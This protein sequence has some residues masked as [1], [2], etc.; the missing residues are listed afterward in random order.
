M[1]RQWKLR[2]KSGKVVS[3]CPRQESN[4]RFLLRREVSYPL[5]DEDG[6]FLANNR[7]IRS[8][9]PLSGDIAGPDF[10]VRLAG[11]GPTTFWTATRR[12]IH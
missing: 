2:T 5:Y 11:I 4:L 3:W 1:I 8:G 12:S 7:A 10:Q 6:S 9:T